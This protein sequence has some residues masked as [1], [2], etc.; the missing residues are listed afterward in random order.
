M[1]RMLASEFSI[2]RKTKKMRQPPIQVHSVGKLLTM[3]LS[4]EETQALERKARKNKVTLSSVQHAA[5]L[6]ATWKHLYNNE[7]RPLKYILFQNLR[8]YLAPPLNEE[9]LGSYIA[10]IQLVIDMD[11][12]RDF[13]DVCHE[14]N[15][16]VYQT[17]KSGDKFISANMSGTLLQMLFRY[18]TFRMAVTAMN[19]SGAI[20][21]QKAYGDTRVVGVRGFA[22]NFGLGPEF[23]AQTLIFNGKLFWNILYL[24]ADMNVDTAQQITDEI[25]EILVS[26]AQE[27]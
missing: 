11:I 24:E 7:N 10:M 22:S 17:G 19:Y 1:I 20:S 5:I 3:N 2:M 25:K 16:S 12:K 14:I 6:T 9:V 8:P 23:S 26:K 4:E 13:W 18:R 21:L 27:E 15:Q